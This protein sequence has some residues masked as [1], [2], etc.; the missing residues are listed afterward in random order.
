MS[1]RRRQ[2]ELLHATRFDLLWFPAGALRTQSGLAPGERRPCPTCGHTARPGWVVDRFD[3]PRPCTVCGGASEPT[4]SGGQWL[5]KDA[6]KGFVFVDRM[7]A[8]RQPIGDA[9]TKASARP[10]R[11]V[12]CDACAGAGAHGN[13]RRCTVCDGDGWRDL[14]RFDL[15]LDTA[16]TGSVDALTESIMRR[17]RAGSYHEYEQALAGVARHVNKPP[18]FAMLTVNAARALR[19]L[20]ELYLPPAVRLEHDLGDQERQLVDLAFAYIDSRMPDPIRVPPDVRANAKLIVERR[21]T[22]K[23]RGAPLKVRDAEIRRLAAQHRAPQWIAAEYGISVSSVYGIV[24][25]KGA[26]A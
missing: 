14:H 8:S 1:D 7:D 9:A 6:G 19:L 5:R 11:R 23:G 15:R 16:G 3:R 2:L 22:A 17:D 18:M 25:R 12:R 10:R 13:G 4:G 24:N 26:A 21:T 20:D